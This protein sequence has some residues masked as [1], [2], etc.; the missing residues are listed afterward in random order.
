M[1]LATGDQVRD[2]RPL[3]GGV[4]SDIAEL[5]VGDLHLC[6]KFA[7]PKLRVQEEWLAPV[8][9]N[10]AEYDWLSFVGWISPAN[11]PRLFGRSEHLHGFVMEFLS[12]ERTYLWKDAMF[13]G[14]DDRSEAVAVAQILGVIHAASTAQD[15]DTRP[16]QNCDDFRTLRIE[17]YLLFTATR[18]PEVAQQLHALA[19]RLYDTRIALVHGDVSPKNIMFRNGAAIILDAECATMGDP[20]FDVAFCLNH[21]LLKAVH[22]P[23]MRDRM[24]SDTLKF[25]DAYLT[26]VSW[27]DPAAL[28]ARVAALVP[29]LLL[30]RVDGKS[31]VEYLRD[32]AHETVR[33]LAKP[34]IQTPPGTL[35]DLVAVIQSDREHHD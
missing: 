23:V 24:L 5:R 19:D 13:A 21:L 32:S 3:R 33:R 17:P 8:H 29:A 16:F 2:V 22:M 34:L 10:K 26:H 12:G 6:V 30:A 18:H 25:C 15:F 31:P 35:A 9:R 28:E 11:A 27:E 1:E 20:A 14:E 7:L 4:A